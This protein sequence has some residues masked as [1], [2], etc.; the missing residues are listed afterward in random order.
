MKTSYVIVQQV[1]NMT[2]YEIESNL[3]TSYVIVQLKCKIIGKCCK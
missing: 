1:E 3:K 2:R